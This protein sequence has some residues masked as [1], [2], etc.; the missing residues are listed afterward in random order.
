MSARKPLK[1]RVRLQEG[2]EE[3]V[4]ESNLKNNS[5]KSLVGSSKSSDS[6]SSLRKR[7]RPAKTNSNKSLVSSNSAEQGRE[8]E[9]EVKSKRVSNLFNQEYFKC[10]TSGMCTGR[11]WPW[12]VH[13]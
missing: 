12:N 9:E 3:E 2:G 1:K 7:G 10:A 6:K 11:P 13:I 4:V 8:G 5:S